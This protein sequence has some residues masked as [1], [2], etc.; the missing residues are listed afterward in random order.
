VVFCGINPG[1]FP[2]RRR[3][4]NAQRLAPP[5][6][7]RLHAPPL[8]PD[9]AVRCSTSSRHHDT[10]Y[11]T[12]RGSGD[13]RAGDF[14]GAARLGRSR[15]SFG[16]D[17]RLRRQAG[18]RAVPRA[19]RHG[20]RG[21]SVRRCCSC[22]PPPRPRTQPSRGRSGTVVPALHDLVSTRRR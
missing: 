8:R 2:M 20:L 7:G 18:V 1:R 9:G 11:R 15:G 14:T 13:L 16:P 10:A 17:D 3:A 6:R 12:A 22:S 5:P 21:R 19:G 4:A